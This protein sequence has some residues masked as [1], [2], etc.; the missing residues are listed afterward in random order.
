[1]PKA[2]YDATKAH[3]YY[4][5]T[6]HLK[7]RKKGQ[8]PTPHVQKHLAKHPNNKSLD[9]KVT[10][11]RG[12]L[13]QLRALLREKKAS[14]HKSA[15]AKPDKN[16]NSVQKAA[17]AQKSRDYYDKHKQSIK[18]DHK[19][20]GSGGGA[21]PGRKTAKDMSTEE[22]QSEIRSLVGQLKQAIANA[23]QTRGG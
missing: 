19:K 9:Q 10:E 5:R 20:G 4:E 18:A 11:I 15:T 13:D 17:D 1:M 21:K 2:P 3:D 16:K 8:A 23:R 12:K 22:L 6:K 14:A 7:G